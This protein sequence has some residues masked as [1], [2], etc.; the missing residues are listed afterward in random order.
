MFA[1]LK[2]FEFCYKMTLPTSP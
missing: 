1:L 2:A